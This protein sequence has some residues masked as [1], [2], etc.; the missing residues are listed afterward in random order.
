MV[1]TQLV[2]ITVGVRLAQR[3]DTTRLKRIVGFVCLAAGL[4]MAVRAARDVLGA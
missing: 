1:A 3:T 4:F 2:G